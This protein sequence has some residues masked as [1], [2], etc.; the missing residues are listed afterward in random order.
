VPLGTGDT[1]FDDVFGGL[2]DLGYS[3]HFVLQAAR[4]EPGQ[5]VEWA[6]R[7]REFVERGWTRSGG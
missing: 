3:G 6:R 2:R 1:D 7:N 5:E 4:G